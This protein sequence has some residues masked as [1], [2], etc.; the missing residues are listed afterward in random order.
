MGLAAA[1]V[2][3]LVAAAP[4]GIPR[5]DEIRLDALVL[6]FTVILSL[7]AGL[8]FGLAPAW[9]VSRSDPNQALKEGGGGSSAGLKVLQVRGLLVAVECALAVVLLTSAGLLMA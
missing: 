3:A 5:L 7:V 4:Q 2:R 8:L 1:G 9:K 6:L